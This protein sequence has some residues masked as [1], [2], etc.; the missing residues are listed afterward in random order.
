MRRNLKSLL[1]KDLSR[2]SFLRLAAGVG[3]ALISPTFALAQ[4]RNERETMLK[5]PI[6][7]SGEPL[8]VIGPVPAWQLSAICVGFPV[9]GI[10]PVTAGSASTNFRRIVS[11]SCSRSRQPNWVAA[12]ATAP[13]QTA[14][15]ER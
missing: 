5:R 7:S 14:A 9:P 11:S 4:T 3:A 1:T 13:Q 10:T 6:P 15:A 8:P 12:D 2:T